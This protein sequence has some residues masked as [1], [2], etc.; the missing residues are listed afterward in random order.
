MQVEF[1]PVFVSLE[2]KNELTVKH[3]FGNYTVSACFSEIVDFT[4]L[5][6]VF[7]REIRYEF[8]DESGATCVGHCVTRW[9][10]F[11]G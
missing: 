2:F 5:D 1:K 10:M 3:S 11:N 4:I 9:I 8:Q 7:V 6:W